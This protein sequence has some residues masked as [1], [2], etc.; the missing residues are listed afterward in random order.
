MGLS[1]PIIVNTQQVTVTEQAVDLSGIENT[2][3]TIKADASA[4]K[5]NAAN[6]FEAAAEGGAEGAISVQIVKAQSA[7]NGES[8]TTLAN[9]TGRGY[10]DLEWSYNT[11]VT[12]TQIAITLDGTTVFN[13]MG[14]KMLLEYQGNYKIRRLP[15]TESCKVIAKNNNSSARPINCELQI[16]LT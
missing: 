15:F 6:A 4:A 7:I 11:Y 16:T 13:D 1:K 3:A 12:D 2:L 9:I 8:S 10:L 14:N 5:T